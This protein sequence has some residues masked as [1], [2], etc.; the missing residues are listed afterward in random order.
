MS[1]TAQHVVRA[2]LPDGRV[3]KVQAQSTG[4]V[5]RDVSGIGKVLD[6]QGVIDSVQSISAAMGKAI[7]KARPDKASVEFG[8]DVGVESGGLTALLVK[9]TGSATLT[10]T[11][12]WETNGA[13]PQT[14]G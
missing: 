8:V 4:N 14:G 5:E 9:G 13:P 10:V 2:K 12:E 7:E 11:L 3:V 1:A 6:F